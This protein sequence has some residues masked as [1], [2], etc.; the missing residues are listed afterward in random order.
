[1]PSGRMLPD[2]FGISTRRPVAA[3]RFRQ[4]TDLGS[5]AS[6]LSGRP[7]VRP[8]SSRQPPPRLCCASLVPTLSSGSHAR[9]LLPSTAPRPP[10]IRDW[11]SPRALRSL[12]RRC[13]GLH[14]PLWCPSSVRSDPSA[15]WLARE[16]QL[17]SPL[18]PF[19]P[20]TVRC[21]L[22]CQLLRC[23]QVALRRPQSRCR[24]TAQTS[25]GKIDRLHRALAGFT[26]PTL[27]DCGLRDQLLAR[28]A[29]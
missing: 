7:A 6:A 3:C 17:Y 28:P 24:D 16:N 2:A 22:L 8:Q 26:T 19:G 5:W 27:D 12:G 13:F 18:P 15:A 20:S 9:P 14:P 4:A 1:M 10:G 23:G 29:G 11:P 25:R 21:R